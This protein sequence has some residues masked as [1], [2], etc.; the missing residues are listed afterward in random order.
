MSQELGLMIG[1][2]RWKVLQGKDVEQGGGKC[3]KCCR[4]IWSR[5]L[6]GAAGRGDVLVP[7]VLWMHK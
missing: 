4:K 2:W 7:P 5:E 3:C 1:A 6:E